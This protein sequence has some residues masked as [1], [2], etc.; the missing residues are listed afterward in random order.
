M[1]FLNTVL[2]FLLTFCLIESSRSF[3]SEQEELTQWDWYQ[4]MTNLTQNLDE[5]KILAQNYKEHYQIYTD[6]KKSTALHWACQYDTTSFIAT[7]LILIDVNIDSQ[8]ENGKTALHWACQTG[9]NYIFDALI[10]KQANI[11]IE[12]NL[13]KTPLYYAIESA[14]IIGIEALSTF[15]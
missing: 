1:L 6:L 7:A 9:N 4:K 13:G 11:H 2:I 3:A 14:F 8:D 10:K 5:F 15:K 12:D